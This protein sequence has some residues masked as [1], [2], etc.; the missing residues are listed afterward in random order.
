MKPFAIDSEKILS[1]IDG[2]S[3]IETDWN[4]E[5]GIYL[6]TQLII[7]SRN[8]EDIDYYLDKETCGI[9][10][11]NG[12]IHY[13]YYFHEDNICIKN[14]YYDDA[15]WYK[16]ETDGNHK[17]FIVASFEQAQ[18]GV[19]QIIYYDGTN[20]YI[21][22]WSYN[23]GI[24]AQSSYILEK[25]SAENSTAIKVKY[26]FSFPYFANISNINAYSS[27]DNTS[28]YDLT[29]VGN[30]REISENGS[31]GPLSAEGEKNIVEL[32]DYIFIDGTGFYE[33]IYKGQQIYIR[34][35]DLIYPL[36]ISKKDLKTG[37][38][39]VLADGL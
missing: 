5:D 23:T 34:E 35:S 30:Q 18:S 15:T 2:D 27:L 16:S 32:T 29:V 17:E 13:F 33:G 4:L 38:N 37:I 22:F 8:A 19:T 9:V 10:I 21:K 6:P 26:D 24:I 14:L 25:V 39:M 7:Q 3:G 11:K 31:R 12:K 28:E 36:Y 1:V 20:I